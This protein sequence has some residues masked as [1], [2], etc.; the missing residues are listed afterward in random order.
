MNWK[1][2][3]KTEFAFNFL[4]N[5]ALIWFELFIGNMQRID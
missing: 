4:E 1:L 5:T 3:I 2:K